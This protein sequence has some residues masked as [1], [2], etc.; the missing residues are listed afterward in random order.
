MEEI[1][2]AYLALKNLQGLKGNI[3][4]IC[5]I[6]STS[7]LSFG[8]LR[9]ALS[10]IPASLFALISKLI[11]LLGLIYRYCIGSLTNVFKAVA[12]GTLVEDRR[13]TWDTW[14]Q[15]MLG[16]GSHSSESVP[17]NNSLSWIS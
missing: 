16:A 8:V 7:S 13:S 17:H 10:C 9:V 5:A 1:D 14:V 12:I 15:N 6:S 11:Y 2:I 4:E 3:T